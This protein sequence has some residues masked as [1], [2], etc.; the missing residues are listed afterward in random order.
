MRFQCLINHQLQCTRKQF[1]NSS[2]NER[3]SIKGTTSEGLG[4]EQFQTP[5]PGAYESPGK[6][7]LYTVYTPC[8]LF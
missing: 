6:I 2:S 8:L 5:G 3:F 4:S 1:V 7:V